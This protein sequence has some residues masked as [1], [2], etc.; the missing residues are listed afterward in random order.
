MYVVEESPPNVEHL[1]LHENV[2]L[3]RGQQTLQGRL[4]TDAPSFLLPPLS[5]IPERTGSDHIQ[6]TY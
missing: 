4:F 3:S 1:D 6:C 5:S 2:N